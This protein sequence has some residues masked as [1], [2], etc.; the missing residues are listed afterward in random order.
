MGLVIDKDANNSV[1]GIDIEA[2]AIIFKDTWLLAGGIEWA[3]GYFGLKPLISIGSK[4]VSKK[5]RL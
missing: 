4:A 3:I 1:N 5:T 2:I